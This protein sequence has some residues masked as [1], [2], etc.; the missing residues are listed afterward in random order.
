[1]ELLGRIIVQILETEVAIESIKK[2]AWRLRWLKKK[3]KPE[4][5]AIQLQSGTC[6][7]YL[8]GLYYQWNMQTFWWISFFFFSLYIWRRKCK[9]LC[10]N[11]NKI[12]L[13][14][15]TVPAGTYRMLKV[16]KCFVARVSFYSSVCLVMLV[17]AY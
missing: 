8:S 17:G 9:L 16:V 1:M 10:H 5:L 6:H 13:D 4:N 2:V 7:S 15:S 12:I 11:S 3:N 14:S